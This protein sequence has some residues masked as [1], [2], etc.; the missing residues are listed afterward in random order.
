LLLPLPLPLPLRLL[1]PPMLLLPPSPEPLK[2]LLP[3]LPE[4]PRLP[5]PLPL[6]EIPPPDAVE[7]PLMTPPVCPLAGAAITA[8][9]VKAIAAADSPFRN[10]YTEP[11]SFFRGTQWY[12][13]P[14]VTSLRSIVSS[15][16][17][18]QSSSGEKG[19]RNVRVGGVVK[20]KVRHGNEAFVR[21]PRDS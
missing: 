13:A 19:M 9:K 21:T 15:D 10:P 20:A 12:A 1:L 2:E 11:P 5:L 8:A 6:V 4:L 18:V 16:F 17:R 3:R 7:P 14:G